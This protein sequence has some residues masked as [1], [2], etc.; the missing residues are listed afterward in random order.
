ME[1]T[2]FN[3]FIREREIWLCPFWSNSGLSF[4]FLISNNIKLRIVNTCE[5]IFV[6]LVNTIIN[7]PHNSPILYL[8]FS[9]PLPFFPSSSIFS[10]FLYMKTGD[11]IITKV[12]LNQKFGI[13]EAKEGLKQKAL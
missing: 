2:A 10:F 9:I 4:F 6:I 7:P 12:G 3:Y 11:R 1:D 13:Y 5:H 8:H